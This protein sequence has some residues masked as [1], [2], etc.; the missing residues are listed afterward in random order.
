MPDNAFEPGNKEQHAELAASLRP[1][2]TVQKILI[3]APGRFTGEFESQNTLITHAWP[4]FHSGRRDWFQDNSP[5]SRTAFVLAF[6]TVRSP[7][8][9]GFVVPNYE[10]AGRLVS[11]VLSVLFG[12][13]FDTHGPL[14][15]SGS[16]GVPDLS[17]FSTPT[18]RDLPHN[19]S[20]LRSNYPVPLALSEVKRIENLIQGHHQDTKAQTTFLTAAR[21]YQR[22]LQ[23]V[24]DDPEIAYL[25]LI[26]AGELLANHRPFDEEK[27]IDPTTRAALARIT[28]EMKGGE[29]LSSLLRSQL[30]GVKRRFV[31]S[32][33]SYLDADFFMQSEA[34]SK[35]EALATDDFD[36]RLGAAYDLR[37]RSVHSGATFGGWIAPRLGNAEIQSGRPIIEGDEKLAAILFKAPTFPGLE[38][39]L[40]CALLGLA[41]EL[42]ADLSG[43]ST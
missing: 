6:R 15:M 8:L 39:T 9:P 32:I 40:R 34:N 20:R 26:T 29:K 5:L 42:G 31:S 24:E 3:S 7:E 27:H 17:Q 38:R 14:E 11:S 12:K 43:L 13:R 33:K 36:K 16:F 2:K 23:T 19:S 21:F 4:P 10:Y 35:Y 25:H 41:L 28:A 18:G 22:A 30:R 1:D 37:S